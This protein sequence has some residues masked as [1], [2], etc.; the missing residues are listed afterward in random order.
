LRP[1]FAES[2]QNLGVLLARQG[3]QG[4]AVAHFREAIRLRADYP[5]ALFNLGLTHFLAGQYAEAEP[6]LREV[7]RLRPDFAEARDY[8]ERTVAEGRGAPRDR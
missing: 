4:E 2:H 1:D 3:R 5:E 7:L 8:L 6:P